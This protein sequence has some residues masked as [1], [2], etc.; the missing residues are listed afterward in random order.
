VTRRNRSPRWLANLRI[1]QNTRVGAEPLYDLDNFSDASIQQWDAYGRSVR[2]FFYA[3]YFDLDG[4]RAARHKEI[5]T[6]LQDVMSISVSLD[7]WCRVISFKYCLSPLSPVGSL[8]WVGQRFNI[9]RD[10]DEAR[11]TSFP[12]LYVAEDFETAF[13][14]YQNLPKDTRTCGLTPEELALERTRQV[15]SRKNLAYPF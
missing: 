10:I 2:D 15:E 8:Q 3:L 5:R 1:G 13:R 4:Q 7:D 14:E 6:A 11:F 12:A 9:G